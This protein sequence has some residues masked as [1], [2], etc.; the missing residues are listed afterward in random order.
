MATLNELIN[1]V[2]TDLAKDGEEGI[3]AAVST[4]ID[5]SIAH[6][7]NTAWWFMETQTSDTTVDGTEYY[8]VPSDM[9]ST[10]LTLLIEVS[11]NTYPLIKR[12]M[13]LLDD[14]F[15]KSTIFTGYSTDYAIWK[16]Q[17]RLY[18]VPNGAYPLTI[19]YYQKLGAPAGGSSNAWTTDA[20]MLI[21]ARTEW[22]LLSLR[23]HDVEAAT[24]A[25]QVEMDELRELKKTNQSRQMTGKTRK[26]RV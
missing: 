1:N 22:Q 7:E 21:R 20:E 17:F 19:N 16:N 4:A 14:W 15:V 2:I 18:P 11:N 24:V 25:K 6:H 3:T 10:E 9:A 23:Y 5:N 26:R 13:Q 12:D 8:D